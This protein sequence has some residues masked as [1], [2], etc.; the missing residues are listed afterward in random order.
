M[1]T[2][3]L[4]NNFSRNFSEPSAHQNASSTPKLAQNA[5][6]IVKLQNNTVEVNGL[7]SMESISAGNIYADSQMS[8]SAP[9]QKSWRFVVL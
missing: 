9:N 7:S 5:D 6:A 8:M 2:Q 3:K 1:K 4:I